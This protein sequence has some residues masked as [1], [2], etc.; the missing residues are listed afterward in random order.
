LELRD[1]HPFRYTD[2]Q[3]DETLDPYHSFEK[4]MVIHISLTGSTTR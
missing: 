4:T 2:Q 3:Q 1:E